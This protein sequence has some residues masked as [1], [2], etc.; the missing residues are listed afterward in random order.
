[1]LLRRLTTLS[2]RRP[3]HLLPFRI[4]FFRI[5]YSTTYTAL[6]ILTLL[7]L[8]IT[9]A[10]ILYTAIS[11]AAYQYVFMTGG[12]YVLTALVAVFIYSSR[13]YTNRSVIAGVGKAY[14]PVEEGEVSKSVGKLVR[15][16]GERSC[17]VAWESRPRDVVGEVDRAEKEGLLPDGE[18]GD[19]TVGRVLSVDPV[20]PH[21]GVIEHAGWSAPTLAAKGRQGG[22]QF[23]TV[24]KELPNLIEAQAVSLAPLVMDEQGSSI[25]EP[26]IVEVLMRHPKMAVREYLTQLSYFGLVNPPAI[27]SDF[28]SRYERARFSGKPAS[29]LQ[30]EDLMTTFALLL[31]GMVELPAA[32]IEEIRLQT[33]ERFDDQ[34]SMHDTASSDAGG[35]VRHFATPE[36]PRSASSVE[37]PVTARTRWSR[38]PTP[39]LQSEA[40][41]SQSTMGSVIVRSPPVQHQASVTDFSDAGSVLHHEVG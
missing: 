37:S 5:F 28:L 31:E 27:S 9:P 13:L 34:S 29:E 23:E 7:I 33:G 24:I 21:W 15:E 39:Y 41:G 11:A 35:S 12:V 17:V 2:H 18:A 38:V 36:P 3:G 16:Q 22:L 30:F 40:A 1:M 25:P 14:I 10:S 26:A 20:K 19:W 32:I 8:A 4:P 6:W